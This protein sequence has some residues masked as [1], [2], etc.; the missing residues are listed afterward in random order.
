[1]IAVGKNSDQQSSSISYISDSSAFGLRFWRDARLRGS[2]RQFSKEGYRFPPDK[3]QIAECD[4][5]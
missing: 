4:I 5:D 1:M 3:T 2:E